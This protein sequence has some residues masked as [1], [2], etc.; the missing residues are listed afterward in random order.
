MRKLAAVSSVL[1]WLTV[2]R[3]H[4]AFDAANVDSSTHRRESARL[5]SYSQPGGGAALDLLP[6]ASLFHS[7]QPSTVTLAALQRRFGLFVSCL[8]PAYDRLASLGYP[9]TQHHRLGDATLHQDSGGKTRRHKA[10]LRAL[11]TALTALE[12]G[13]LTDTVALG[14]RDDRTAAT[15]EAARLRHAHINAT[16]VPDLY[17]LGAFPWIWE[18]KAFS[19]AVTAP[20][21]GGGTPRTGSGPCTADGWWVALGGTEEHLVRSTLG[22]R[23]RG[24]PGAHLASRRFDGVGWVRAHAGDYADGL[25]KGYGLTLCV[26]ET[27]GAVSTTVD[28]LYRALDRVSREPGTQD[29]TRYGVSRAS[30]S[31]FR[32]HHLAAHACAVTYA[33]AATLLSDSQSKGFWLARGQPEHAWPPRAPS[34]ATGAADDGTNVLPPHDDY[35]KLPEG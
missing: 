9:V 14:D 23:E 6:D 31:T 33:D 29:Y 5:V 16:H 12:T 8:A 2:K 18:Y 3:Q 22:L 21:F 24:T 15:R 13:Q 26:A 1:A 20:N 28:R 25:S 11:H 17:R 35:C 10:G 27:S 4:D 32:R 34:V 19:W 30:P 7:V